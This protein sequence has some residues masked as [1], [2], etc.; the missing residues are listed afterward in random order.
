MRLVYLKYPGGRVLVDKFEER[1]GAGVQALVFL[2]A[3]KDIFDV[4][5]GEKFTSLGRSH[6][7]LEKT[8]GKYGLSLIVDSFGEVAGVDRI[9]AKNRYKITGFVEGKDRGVGRGIQTEPIEGGFFVFG[10]INQGRAVVVFVNP[11]FE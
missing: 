8:C 9:I 7:A 10:G 1:E 3:E 4:A 11:A 5:G 2:E 6:L